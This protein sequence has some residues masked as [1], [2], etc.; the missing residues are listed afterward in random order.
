MS[1]KNIRVAGIL[2]GVVMLLLGFKVKSK[3][4]KVL[5]LTFGAFQVADNLLGNHKADE[6]LDA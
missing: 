4:M 6:A 1:A 2:F 3:R 5:L